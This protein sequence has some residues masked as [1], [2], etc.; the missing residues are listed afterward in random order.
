MTKGIKELNF[1]V[2]IERST[3]TFFERGLLVGLNSK[4]ALDDSVSLDL[5]S[6][7]L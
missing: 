3:G 5:S 4:G 6:R 7:A 1:M 2:V